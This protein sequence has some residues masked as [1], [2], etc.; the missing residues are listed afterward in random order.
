MFTNTINENE[1]NIARSSCGSKQYQIFFKGDFMIYVGID[2]S[3]DK[4]DCFITNSD[5]VEQK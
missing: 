2:V 4:H 3:K 1:V 5:G